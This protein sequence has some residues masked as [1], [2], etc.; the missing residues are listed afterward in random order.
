MGKKHEKDEFADREADK[1]ENPI[2]S[3]EFILKHLATRGG[4]ATRKQLILELKLETDQELEAFR[5]R[6]GAMVRDGQLHK[7]RRGTYGPVEKM[8]LISGR[9]IGHKDGFGFFVADEGGD[10]LFLNARQ[11][12]MVFHGDRALAR[13]SGTDH[14]GGST[15]T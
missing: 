5:R 15:R 8:E 4:P 3:R 9:V 12:R 2:P 13:V 11:M 6:I 7:N 1:Y 10:D 14:R